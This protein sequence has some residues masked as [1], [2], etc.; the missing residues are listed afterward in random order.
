MIF[1]A[2]LLNIAFQIPFLPALLFWVIISAT[3]PLA[4]WAILSKNTTI[5]ESKKLLIEWESI[6]ND[7]F[8]VTVFGILALIIFEWHEF[9]L[10]SSSYEFLYHIGLAIIIWVGFGRWV[11]FMLNKWHE[12]HFTLSINMTILLTFLSFA[13]AESLHASWIIAVFVAALAYWYK[14][15]KDNEN[16]NIHKGI[17]EYIEYLANAIL[18]FA[19]GASFISQTDIN[20]IGIGFIL[21]SL[22]MLFVARAIALGV[23]L[24][25]LRLEGKKFS[26]LDFLLLHLAGSRWAV[27]VALILLLP[28]SFEYKWFFLSLA[29]CV[30]ILSLIV[31]PL[32]LQRLI[33]K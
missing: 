29:F 16:K 14:P 4:V 17:W 33:K 2:F 18:F 7:G 19:L 28:D 24:P 25:M 20:Y 1:I 21:S 10:L 12:K 5:P 15:E 9:E 11:R 22:V 6:L 30:I 13:L 32:I 8:V 26:L 31:N 23:L 3:D 27:S